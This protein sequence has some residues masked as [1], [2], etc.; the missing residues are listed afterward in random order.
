M[1]KS[2]MEGLLS[3]LRILIVDDQP[4]S[5]LA[6]KSILEDLSVGE[7]FEADDGRTGALFLKKTGAGIDLILCDW[8][9]PVMSGM[10]FYHH[11]RNQGNATP[12]L[13]IT[14]RGDHN[15]VIE[16]RSMGVNGYIR[17]P[18]APQQIEAK[19]RILTARVKSA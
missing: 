10:E 18:F 1:E 8:N 9:M 15:S 5:R 19:L 3:K 7:V 17:K 12:F 6:L 13:M 16:A 11:V 4:E 2:L 14:G